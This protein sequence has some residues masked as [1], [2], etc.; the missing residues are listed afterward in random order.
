MVLERI[1]IRG[2]QLDQKPLFICSSP[3]AFLG[4]LILQIDRFFQTSLFNSK[5]YRA[6]AIMV[7]L[8]TIT[9][10]RSRYLKMTAKEFFFSLLPIAG[11]ARHFRYFQKP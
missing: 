7:Y 5:I 1:Q 2:D 11:V 9:Y 8:P 4:M 6:I 3:G 10:L